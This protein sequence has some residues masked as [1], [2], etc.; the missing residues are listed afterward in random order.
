MTDNQPPATSTAAAE[1][2]PQPPGSVAAAAAAAAA[3]AGEAATTSTT[4]AATATT[5]TVTTTTTTTTED[6]PAPPPPP[7]AA[8][9]AAALSAVASLAALALSNPGAVPPATH[10]CIDVECV[11]TGTTHNDRAVAQIALVVRKGASGKKVFLGGFLDSFFP[12]P[13]PSLY[14]LFFFFFLSL[15]LFL[16]SPQLQNLH[17]AAK[18]PPL[19][20]QN[21][22]SMS[23]SS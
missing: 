11:A 12:R 10:F 4:T 8:G 3:P 14:H 20:S 19:S 6:A 5:V 21:R 23:A 18:K 17:R 7:G 13:P 16:H 15:S 1:A 22:T 2:Q 9:L